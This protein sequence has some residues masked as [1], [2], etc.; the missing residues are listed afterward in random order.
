MM[1]NDG[2][3]RVF[4]SKYLP[5]SHFAL[6]SLSWPNKEMERGSKRK[7]EAKTEL[8]PNTPLP[9]CLSPI[10]HTLSL[11][12]RYSLMSLASFGCHLPRI[13]RIG[14]R[15]VQTERIRA[16]FSIVASTKDSLILAERSVARLL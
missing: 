16:I 11:I 12:L 1:F 13:E 10:C 9:H 5:S 8:K 2:K 14:K 15:T 4:V 3:R 6:R 7:R